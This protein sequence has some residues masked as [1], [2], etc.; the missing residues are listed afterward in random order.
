ML[1]HSQRHAIYD[2][3]WPHIE[4]DKQLWTG[5]TE[6]AKS[7][8]RDIPESAYFDRMFN[9]FLATIPVAFKETRKGHPFYTQVDHTIYHPNRA[10][11]HAD[12]DYYASVL[13]EVGHWSGIITDRRVL[14][15][16]PEE[17]ILAEFISVFL[18]AALHMPIDYAWHAAY[19]RDWA[20]KYK[21]FTPSQTSRTHAVFMMAFDYTNLILERTHE[22][23]AA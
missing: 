2:L 22:P 23:R 7:K 17:E 9:E 4:N 8:T 10:R 12:R 18:Q 1:T 13:H 11:F 3:M 21:P 6:R 14:P 16:D 20:N 15:D 19:V 5:R